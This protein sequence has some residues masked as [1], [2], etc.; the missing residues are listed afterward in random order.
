MVIISLSS[1]EADWVWEPFGG[2]MTGARAAYRLKRAC[3]S[4]EIR[5]SPYQAAVQRFIGQTEQAL[6]SQPRG[7][8]W[9]PT[10]P[11]L[12]APY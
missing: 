4:A 9:Q 12:N 11:T 5:T 8:G 3:V 6:D 1:D 2:L 10:P 7:R